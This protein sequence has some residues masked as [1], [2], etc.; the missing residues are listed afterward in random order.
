[1]CGLQRD[2]EE[3]SDMVCWRTRGSS[4]DLRPRMVRAVDQGP[5]QAEI[6]AACQISVAT[7]K[8]SLKQRRATGYVTATPLPG[9]PPTQRAA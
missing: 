3:V 7:I 5:R 6:A 1:M 4:A 9:R 2:A 8:R